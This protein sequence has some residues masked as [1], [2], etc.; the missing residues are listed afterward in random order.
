VVRLDSGICVITSAGP[1]S[2]AGEE[3]RV[4]GAYEANQQGVRVR[5]TWSAARPQG[6]T[7]EEAPAAVVGYLPGGLRRL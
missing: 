2:Y 4:L 7:D 1:F 5:R 3:E 6:R